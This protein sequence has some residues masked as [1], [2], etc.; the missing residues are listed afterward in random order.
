M[1]S[2][3]NSKREPLLVRPF[4]TP[5]ANPKRARVHTICE[6]GV[7]GT[8]VFCPASTALTLPSSP[9]NFYAS[10]SSIV[11]TSLISNSPIRAVAYR[12]PSITLNAGFCVN[13]GSEFSAWNYSCQQFQP[14]SSEETIPEN[15]IVEDNVSKES[16]IVLTISPNPSSGSFQVSFQMKETGMVNL[17]LL[18]MEGRVTNKILSNEIKESGLHSITVNTQ[19]LHGIYILSIET[20]GKKAT[21]KVVIN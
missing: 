3:K 5:V 11:S 21:S 20:G 14:R 19:G 4:N 2:K 10:S 16:F 12:A 6:R 7:W 18:N 8:P 13:L 15:E 9:I 17:S 1:C